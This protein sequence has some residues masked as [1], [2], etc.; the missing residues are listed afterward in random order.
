M[1]DTTFAT[2]QDSSA[3]VSG[4]QVTVDGPVPVEPWVPRALGPAG[5]TVVSTV[6][7]ML[8]FAA[9]HLDDPSL[10]E[11]RRP[12]PAPRIYGWLDGWCLGWAWFD[13]EGG[14]VWGWDSVL[15]GER[16]V[17]RLVPERRAAIVL[18]TNGD[19]GRAL[20]RSLF[21]ELMHSCF[22]ITVPPLR[23]DAQPGSAGDLTRFTGVYAWPDRRVEVTATEAGLRIESE[24]GV[25]QALPLDEQT[26]VVDATDPD[27][28]TVTFG[29]FDEA[30]RPRVLYVMLWGLPRLGE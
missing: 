17:L 8:R 22:D 13:W 12:Q 28:P 7:D 5:T 14:R 20:Y 21:P 18:M 15:P 6:G 30:G 29:S 3:R 23:L 26:F 10:A 27:N 1:S 11:L 16:A 9:L 2:E 19:S 4:H 25:A 24:D